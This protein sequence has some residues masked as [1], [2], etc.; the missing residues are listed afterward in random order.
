MTPDSILL[1][2]HSPFFRVND[3]VF[4]DTQAQNGLRLYAENFDVVRIMAPLVEGPQDGPPSGASA[5]KPFLDA[6]PT[7]EPVML[8]RRGTVK[9]L[10][11]DLRPGRKVIREQIAA[12]Q[13]LVFGFS[14]YIGDWGTV[15]CRMAARMDR[16]YAVFKDLVGHRSE[17]VYQRRMRR[18][19]PR[20]FLD[21][22]KNILMEYS[23]RQVV[24]GSAL[25][26]L[27][28]RDTL[29][30]YSAFASN[31][32]LVHNIH[33]SKADHISDAAL[34]RRLQERDPNML[35]L[36]Y[37]GR[38]EEVKGPDDWIRAIENALHQGTRLCATWYGT[39]DLLD[40]QRKQV[41][42]RGLETSVTFAGFVDHKQMLSRLHASDIFL[43][44]H[45]TEES[46]RCLIEALSAGLP[47]VGY[48]SAYP[49]DLVGAS[50]A[51]LFVPRGDTA[52]LARALQELSADPERL[53]AMALDA[54]RVAEPLNDEDVF[55]HRSDIIKE[56][57]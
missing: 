21:W 42:D 30:H 22:L 4:F 54:R 44:T 45:L 29:D 17:R 57:L 20:R 48:D 2:S 47:L 39:G 14:G 3:T 52:A 5:L 1:F 40:A 18:S 9:F 12:S 15:A 41:A 49:R 34:T 36:S 11:R 16:P 23:D 50:Q 32:R 53:K 33:I 31:P 19:A 26:L 7:V 25:A 8:P 46:P 13:Y 6:H 38:V 51:G 27:H 28:G 10:T 37:A 55:R 35:N 24:R 43:F 56:A